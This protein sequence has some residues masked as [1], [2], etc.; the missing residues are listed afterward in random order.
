[1]SSGHQV[2]LSRDVDL[3]KITFSEP[4][5]NNNG[6]RTIFINYN[7]GDLLLQTPCMPAPFGICMWPGER[8]APDKYSLDLSFAGRE[9]NQGIQE[10]H[11]MLQGLTD[12]VCK[13]ALE[14]SVSWLK[15]AAPSRDVIEQLF[16]KMIRYSKDKVTGNDSTVYPPSFKLNLPMRDGS[17]AFKTYNSDRSELDLASLLTESQRPCKGARVTAIIQLSS[18]W[19]VG[20]NQFGVSWKVQ[21]LRMQMPATLQGYFFVRDGDEDGAADED[22]AADEDGAAKEDCAA[23]EDGAAKRSDRSALGNEDDLFM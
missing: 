15:K 10:F 6:G 17:F 5:Q 20:Q 11:K 19:V 14:R 13:T 7:G 18:I 1:M 12:V 23:K 4:K 3:S 2:I 21:T 8:G 9:S 16:S 22:C